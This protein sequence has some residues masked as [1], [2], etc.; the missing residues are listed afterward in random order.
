[1]VDD[2]SSRMRGGLLPY[3]TSTLETL[4]PRVL[5]YTPALMLHN[6]TLEDYSEMIYHLV[7]VS[8]RPSAHSTSILRALAS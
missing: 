5:L 7:V 4:M 6:I 3:R 1:M 2:V 8:L